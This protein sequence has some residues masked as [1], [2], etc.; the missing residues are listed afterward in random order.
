MAAADWAVWVTFLRGLATGEGVLPEEEA[1]L[2][3]NERFGGTGGGLPKGIRVYIARVSEYIRATDFVSHT[4]GVMQGGDILLDHTGRPAGL[5]AT[6]G[7]ITA[8]ES[9]GLGNIAILVLSRT[10]SSG[11]G[12]EARMDA[13]AKTVGLDLIHPL[14]GQIPELVPRP[15]DIAA[16]SRVFVPVLEG[17]DTSL[18]PESLRSLVDMLVPRQG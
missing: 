1:R 14:V 4:V 5:S 3:L 7:P 15:I 12:H 18:L 9:I 17:T 10:Y 8:S 11:P 6:T 13:A 2:L 16:V